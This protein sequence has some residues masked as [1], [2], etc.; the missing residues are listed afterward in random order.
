MRPPE[1]R[2]QPSR[3]GSV[4]HPRTSLALWLRTGRAQRGMSLDD[5]A[6]VTKIQPRI[7]ERL[8]A[9]RDDGL[10]AEVFV[11]GFVRSFARCVGLDEAEALSRFEACN[12]IPPTAAVASTSVTPV[13]SAPPAARAV[14][15]AMADLAPTVAHRATTLPEARQSDPYPTSPVD[16]DLSAAGEEASREIEAPKPPVIRSS[17]VKPRK[18]NR[19]RKR[20][21]MASGTPA[22][23]TPV[24]AEVEPISTEQPDASATAAETIPA[25]AIAAEEIAAEALAAEAVEPEAIPAEAVDPD[26]IPAEAIAAEKIAAEALAAEAVEPETI[27]AAA[28]SEPWTPRMPPLASP[29]VSWHRSPI[30]ARAAAPASLVAVIDDAD[31]DSAERAHEERHTNR[32]A[33]R[34]FLPPILL[35]REDRRQGGLTLAVIILLIAATLTLSYLMRRPSSS[36]DGVTSAP[37]ASI[38]LA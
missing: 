8:E 38:D 35:D 12:A 31:P 17:S 24:V 28:S 20:K 27:P 36:G 11:R 1:H 9:G 14:V 32:E 26:A 33:R 15:E 13:R 34:T 16:A 37:A 23:A 18:K 22:I 29:S 2:E 30:A 3:L 7:L 6:R 21:T 5:V 19:A 4:I 10:P 25:E